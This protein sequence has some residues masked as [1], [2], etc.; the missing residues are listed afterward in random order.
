[1]PQLGTTEQAELLLRVLKHS[2][3]SEG[4]PPI[5]SFVER[6][7]DCRCFL[8]EFDDHGAPLARFGGRGAARELGDLFGG[9]QTEGGR[10]ALQFLLSEASLFYPY[11]KT[12]LARRN[13][14]ANSDDGRG[15]SLAVSRQPGGLLTKPG[16]ISPVW[17]TETSTILFSCMFNAF[18]PE[19]I[20]ID[21]ART[22][23]ETLVQALMPGLNIHFQLDR[24]RQDNQHRQ[25]LLSNVDVPALLV[26]SAREILVETR[27]GAEALTRT[28]V[29]DCRQ[30]RIVVTNAR[31][32]A[33]LAE[34]AVPAPNGPAPAQAGH[35]E[36][37]VWVNEDNGT[38]K[39]VSV[40]AVRPL[41]AAPDQAI[42]PVFL[43]RVATTRD[44]PEEIEKCLQT[45]FD[46]SQ[47]EAHLA[48]HLTV[49]GSMN[50]TVADLRITRNTAKTH[51]RRIYEK[52]GV[53]T[54]LQLAR[55]V[56]S[57]AQLF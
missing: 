2:T 4:W 24:E 28:G 33:A 9:I 8:S 5:L 49:T 56:H 51:L 12:G 48:R 6:T 23:F 53:N 26:N 25:L 11:C 42:P 30:R 19:T 37:S 17:R 27:G 43:I 16:L 35:A 40:T 47:S 31:L 55:L 57:L 13:G 34:L 3:Q 44:L 36:R 10:S 41:D 39:R 38:Q 52:T 32:E 54:Q 50:A 46:L 18:T 29:A 22:T 14:T 45:R 20:N 15:H 21:R 1:M 7:L